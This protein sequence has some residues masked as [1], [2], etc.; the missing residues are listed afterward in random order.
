MDN[1]SERVDSVGAD[2]R[3]AGEKV[4]SVGGEVMAVG[5]KVDNVGAEVRIVGEQ[6]GN[7]QTANETLQSQTAD[8]FATLSLKYT[9]VSCTYRVIK[10]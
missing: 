3:A 5:E 4:E 2:V 6:V 7:V 8:N 9:M 10:E 1:V